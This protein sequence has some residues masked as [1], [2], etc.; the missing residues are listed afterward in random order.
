[1][2][3]EVDIDGVN[4]VNARWWRNSSGDTVHRAECRFAAVPW[5]G[6]D[7]WDDERMEHYV[8][9]LGW[10]KAC[11]KCIKEWEDRRA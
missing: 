7:E 2:R 4:A 10:M 5:G 1:M 6:K 3:D 8:N 9:T 11:R